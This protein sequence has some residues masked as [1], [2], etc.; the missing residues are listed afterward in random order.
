[1]TDAEHK[2]WWHLRRMPIKHTH[3]RR[4]ATVGPYF[5]DFACHD[6]RLIIEVDGGQ[7]NQKDHIVADK[8]RTEYL[9]SQGYRV[10][11]FWNNDVL[12]NIDGVMESIYGALCNNEER[13]PPLTPPHR[14]AGGGEAERLRTVAGNTAAESPADVAGGPTVSNSVVADTS[15]SDRVK[16]GHP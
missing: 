1:M 5:A 7:H 8:K 14:F 9:D 12:T 4:Q 16:K 15:A 6:K 11:R 2:L 13:P 3:F 10:L